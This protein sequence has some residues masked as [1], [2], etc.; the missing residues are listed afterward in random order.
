MVSYMNSKYF[1]HAIVPEDIIYFGKIFLQYSLD[2][3]II[4][5]RI[6]G[7]QQPYQMP[8]VLTLQRQRQ[9]IL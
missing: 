9:V 8:F 4:I 6:S 3:N 2:I 7:I 5:G 1:D